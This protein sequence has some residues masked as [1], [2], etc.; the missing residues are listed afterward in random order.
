MTKSLGLAEARFS[1]P[2]LL[3]LTIIHLLHIV[4]TDGLTFIISQLK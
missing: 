2:R 1:L 4:L 3:R